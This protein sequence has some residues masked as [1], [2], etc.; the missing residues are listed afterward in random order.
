MW[1]RENGEGE[2]LKN[3]QINQMWSRIEGKER[4][5]ENKENVERG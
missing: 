5:F 3:K 1:L 2:L 4:D